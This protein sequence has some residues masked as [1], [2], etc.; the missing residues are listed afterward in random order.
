M[1]D[2]LS[3]ADRTLECR[4]WRRDVGGK[5]VRFVVCR[6][7][8]PGGSDPLTVLSEVVGMAA[9]WTLARVRRY[10]RVASSRRKRNRDS[11]ELQRDGA[12]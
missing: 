9:G 12:C 11:G 5:M 3:R 7:G 4:W 8:M 1:V 10:G 2:T 6:K